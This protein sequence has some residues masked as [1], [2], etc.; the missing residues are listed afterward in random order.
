MKIVL[1]K[2]EVAQNLFAV[3]NG[4]NFGRFFNTKTIDYEIHFSK[5]E[6]LELLEKE[7]NEIRDEIKNDD[8]VYKDTSDFTN[9][10]YCSLS[11]LFNYETDFEDLIKTYLHLTLFNK[12][13]TKTSKSKYV[14]NSTEFI[15]IKEN[16]VILK[17]KAFK[18]S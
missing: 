7:Y 17:G 15:R 14:I 11:E 12:I 2:V 13:F 10:N 6:I 16:T 1:N 18:K 4:L 8:E 9:T 3:N 5:N